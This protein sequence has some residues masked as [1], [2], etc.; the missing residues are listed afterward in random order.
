[1]LEPSKPKLLLV[2]LGEC[3]ASGYLCNSL[4]TAED[5]GDHPQV[6]ILH[7]V[8]FVPEVLNIPGNNC[9]ALGSEV[10][11]TTPRFGW[12][13]WLAKQAKAGLWPVLPIYLV[14]AG[15]GGSTSDSWQRHRYRYQIFV[16]RVRAMLEAIGGAHVVI[17]YNQGANEKDKEDH[18]FATHVRALVE[19]VRE[20]LGPV[21]FIMTKNT[22]CSRHLD[23]GLEAVARDLPDVY[24]ADVSE[25]NQMGM[26]DAQHWT[27]EGYGSVAD[28]LWAQTMRWYLKT[29]HYPEPKQA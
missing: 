7:N 18:V 11:D 12:E 2:F 24:L 6:V 15:H 21:P 25:A 3:N 27:K 9:H 10:D 28:A 1:M 22:P 19:R 5:K 23:A 13:L 16:K 29:F 4:L 26:T 14:K 17:W 20:D 8:T